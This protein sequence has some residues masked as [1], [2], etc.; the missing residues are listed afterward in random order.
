LQRPFIHINLAIDEQGRVAS[1]S[2]S[3]LAISC[4]ADWR[5]VHGLRESCDAVAVGARTWLLDSPSLT[6]RSERLGREPLRQPARV[7]FAGAHPC[8]VEPDGRHT[9]VV[10]TDAPACEN[11]VHI[12]SRC[13]RLGGPLRLLRR[14]G[15]RSMLVEGGPT[16]LR[17]FLSAGYADRVTL[18]VRTRRAEAALA[19]SAKLGADFPPWAEARPLGSGVLLVGR[20]REGG[21]LLIPDEY[22]LSAEVA[23]SVD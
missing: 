18:Y 22:G 10:G 3:P 16:L 13:W 20:A 12:R 4:R 5:R 23:A 11:L 6:A 19:A 1:A 9:F 8:P 17:S 21:G 14:H 2:G 7:I 15:I